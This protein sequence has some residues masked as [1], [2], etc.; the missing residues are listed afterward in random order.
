MSPAVML[1][2][3]K[4]IEDVLADTDIAEPRALADHIIDNV[5]TPSDYEDALRLSLPGYVREFVRLERAQAI[6]ALSEPETPKKVRSGKQ[7]ASA[8]W[9]GT[10]ADDGIPGSNHFHKL[11]PRP[12][13]SRIPDQDRRGSTHLS[14]GQATS[15]TQ[16]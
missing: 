2:L 1:N 8:R 4:L 12:M 9:N 3:R 5:L 16:M 7:N 15:V 11:D 13:K 14:R 10:R 6:D